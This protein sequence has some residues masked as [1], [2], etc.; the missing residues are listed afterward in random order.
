MKIKHI[1]FTI[2]LFFSVIFINAQDKYEFMIIEYSTMDNVV[3]MSIDGL[4][5]KKEKINWDKHDKSGYNANPLLEKVKEYQDKDW[6]VMNI[7]TQIGGGYTQGG[8]TNNSEIYF[9]YLRKK[10]K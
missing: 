4:E 3:S 10:I 2:A 6:E 7:N 5:F 9:A 1:L 8:S